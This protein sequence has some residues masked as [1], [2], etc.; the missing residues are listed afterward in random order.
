M[1]E[2]IHNLKNNTNY[3]YYKLNSE[4]FTLDCGISVL[5]HDLTGGHFAF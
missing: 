1:Y 5:L 4:H 2:K 3:Y